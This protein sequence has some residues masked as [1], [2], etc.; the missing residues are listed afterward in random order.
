MSD[1][2]FFPE[3]LCLIRTLSEHH[4]NYAL[5]NMIKFNQLYLQ[6]GKSGRWSF[7]L[8]KNGNNIKKQ[9]FFNNILCK[10]EKA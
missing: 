5:E 4:W 2:N 8:C 1:N 3:P 10:E 9:T 7:S 6:A